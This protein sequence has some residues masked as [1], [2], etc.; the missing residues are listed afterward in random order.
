MKMREK[1][2]FDFGW[3]FHAG[4]IKQAEPI[5]KISMYRHAKTERAQ[6]G[7]AAYSYNEDDLKNIEYWETVDLP[8]DYI[9]HQKPDKNYNCTLGY[10]K[11][12]NAWYRNRFRLDDSDRN[13]RISLLFEGVATH[14]T[15]Y[16]NGCLMARNFCG[17]T[18]FE[19]DVT[20]VARFDEDN[21]V[22]VYVE[23]DDHEGWWYEGAGIY[24]HV[25]LIKTELVSVDLWGVWVNPQKRDDKNWDVP[26]ETTLRNDSIKPAEVWVRSS[27]VDRDGNEK[28][29]ATDKI[30]IQ[31][32]DKAV[33]KQLLHIKN[34]VLWDIDNPYLYK[35]HTSVMMEKQQTSCLETSSIETC[36]ADSSE[37]DTDLQ[38]IDAVDTRFGFRTFTFCA[39]NGFFLNGRNVKIKGVCCH[40]DYGLTGK[41]MPD[42][43][44]RYRLRRL[45]EMGANG[46]RTAHYPHAEASM[47]ALD[48]L[49]FL[50]M[51][52]TRWLEST[53]E[54]L[55]QLEML[56][57]RDRNHPSII[58]WS[59]GNEE[60]LFLKEQGKRIMQTLK[61]FVKKYDPSRPVTAAVSGDPL[62]SAVNEAVDVIG[63][64]Y[65]LHQYDDIHKK[66]PNKPIVASECCAV[67]TTR[68]W[69]L[70]DDPDKGYFTAYDHPTGDFRVTREGTWKH[71]MERPW[72]AGEFQWAGIEHRGETVWPRLCSQSGAL[73]LFLQPKDAYYQNMSHWTDAPMVHLLPHWNLQGREGEIIPVWVYTNC[74]EVELFQDGKSLGVKRPG[75]YT[76]LEWQVEYRPGVLRVEG[77]NKGRTVASK[78][79]ETTGPAAVLK[80]R[81]EDGNVRA[82]NEDVAIVTCWCEDKEGRF[83]PDASPLVHFSANRFGKIIGTGS[84]VCDHIPVNSPSRQMRA[85]LCSLVV[86]AGSKAGTLR[87]YAHADGLVPARLDIELLETER[88]PHVRR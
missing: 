53:K 63:I 11:Y 6:W 57:K 61:A 2:L 9:I 72:V 20:D 87:I 52:E 47:D 22:A 28:A 23:A 49:G 19:V 88:R 10:F 69:Y 29:A 43:V 86:K 1:L 73:D 25:W 78:T 7:P 24:R 54:G 31:C 34:P 80:L 37:P 62:N 36:P 39:E 66:Y 58:L 71:I 3:R 32:K 68:G 18:S 16:V 50:V 83:V 27:I 15:V 84:D 75:K 42:R 55:E 59:L 74:E 44:H 41:A 40:Q 81:L 51:A 35:L 85:G 64:N 45:K 70:D 13:K 82:D 60:P 8:H 30:H 46:Y 21:V 14:A 67:G 26:V 33:L 77:R 4:D 56:L 48:E 38:E 5:D 65:S 12:H 79:V 17:Y 76:H